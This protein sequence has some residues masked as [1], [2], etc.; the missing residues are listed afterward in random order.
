MHNLGM[1]LLKLGEREEDI[2]RIAEARDTFEELLT[3]LTPDVAP[4]D[5]F[6]A[7]NNLGY[8]LRLLGELGDQISP[9]EEAI[10]QLK[11]TLPV[12]T[13]TSDQVGYALIHLN[14]AKAY[15]VLAERKSDADYASLCREECHEVLAPFA[16]QA[17]ANFVE[18]VDKILTRLDVV[19]VQ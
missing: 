15:L 7:A 19:E 1:C 5:W 10:A 2:K 6:N 12:I 18:E 9:I 14:L 17:P 8:A 16:G 13:P 11:K 4:T 3:D